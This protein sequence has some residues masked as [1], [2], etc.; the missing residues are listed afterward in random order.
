M[1][2]IELAVELL[3]IALGVAMI[4]KWR[5][6]PYTIALVIWGLILGLLQLSEEPA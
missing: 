6:R 1:P 3:L 5:Q 2:D 4:S